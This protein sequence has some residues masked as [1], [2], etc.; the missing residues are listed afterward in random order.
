LTNVERF[1]LV[2][3]LAALIA[4]ATAEMPASFYTA[5]NKIDTLNALCVK[6]YQAGVIFTETYTDF[7][8]LDK[9]TTIVARDLR[10]VTPSGANESAL[11]A[12]INSNVIGHARLS[13]KSLDPRPDAKGHHSVLGSNAEDLT[14]VFSI[15][16]L[17]QLW[18]N[19]TIRGDR[20]EWLPCA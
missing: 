17:I 15:N 8:H 5:M 20:I 3:I 7:E 18:S 10:S 12:I 13:W 1:F 4:T 19:V 14:G 2:V 16:K 9:D 11:D 6:N